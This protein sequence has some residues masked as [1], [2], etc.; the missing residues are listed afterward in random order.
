MPTYHVFYE[1]PIGFIEIISDETFI[2]SCNF[3]ENEG[4]ITKLPKI[5]V[6]ALAQIGQYFLKERT[7][8]DLLLAP[9]GTEFQQKVWVEL[10]N[11]PY[12]ETITYKE[13]A[14]RIGKKSAIRAAGNANSKNPIS[15]IIP[16]HRVVGSNG[17]LVGYGGGIERKKWLLEFEKG[18]S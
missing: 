12:G 2:Y 18:N 9:S 1:S 15:I 7:E 14:S 17:D 3:V 13:L 16:C 11:I 8:F 6:K 4:F 10:L 5:L